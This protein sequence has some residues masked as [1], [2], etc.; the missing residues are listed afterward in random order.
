M[1]ILVI[2]HQIGKSAPGIVFERVLMGLAKISGVVIDVIACDYNP[3]LSLVLRRVQVVPYPHLHYRLHNTIFKLSETDI[4]AEYLKYRIC[5]VDKDYDV[6][7]SLCSSGHL[8]G[9][10]VG[11]KLRKDLGCRFGCYLVDAVPAPLGWSKNDKLYKSTLNAISRLLQNVDFLASVNDKML[12]YQESLFVH[13]FGFCSDVVYPPSLDQHINTYLFKRDNIFRFVFTG[14]IYGRRNPEYIIKAFSM[15]VEDYPNTE[16][17]FIGN[18]GKDLIEKINRDGAKVANKILVLSYIDNLSSFYEK[19]TALIDIDADLD[20]D[21]F[22]SSKMSGYLTCNRP[23]I[24]ETGHNSPSRHLFNEIPSI[25]QCEHNPIELC[26]AMS[27]CIGHF[28]SFD[29]K[30]RDKALSLFDIDRNAR[31][32]YR[33]LLGENR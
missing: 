8:F 7:L 16:L 14:N 31:V 22:L 2:A 17:V 23:I 11:N 1:K 19:A 30:D 21:V 27:Y 6:V 29:Y 18:S 13:K 28:E 32:L 24:C 3:S 10:I 25:L 4:I 5:K 15:L 12:K 33:L 20:N 26:Q 9:L